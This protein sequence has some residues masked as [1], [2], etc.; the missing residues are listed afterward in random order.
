MK[1]LFTMTILLLLA[2]CS[3]SSD[4]TANPELQVSPVSSPPNV[5]KPKDV[6]TPQAV[7]SQSPTPILPTP[8]QTPVLD[9][10]FRKQQEVVLRELA[11]LQTASPERDLQLAWQSKDFRFIAVQTVATQIFGVKGDIANPIVQKYQ[12]QIIEGTGDFRFSVEQ[13]QLQELATQYATRY[14]G[15]LMERLFKSGQES[16]E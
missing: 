2:G 15:L 11:R 1:Q 8:S 10:R 13:A 5:S 7:Q 4:G 6:A 9:E 3:S 12:F 16:R 14:N